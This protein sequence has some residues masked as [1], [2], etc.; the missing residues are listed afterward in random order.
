M[1]GSQAAFG[2]TLTWRLTVAVL[3]RFTNER[4]FGW[5][6]WILDPLIMIAVYAVILGGVLGVVPRS[7]LGTY[8][9]FLAC[10]LIP[11]RWNAVSTTRAANAFLSN[12]SLL[13][14]TPVNRDAV[15]LAELCASSIQALMGIPVLIGFMLFYE[16]AFSINLLW[17]PVPLFV[18]GVFICGVGYGLCGLT[19]LLRDTANAY[20]SVL[21]VLWFLSP[22]L[23][24]LDRV[25]DQWRQI[26]IY[27]N[28]FAG[29]LEGVRRPIHDGLPPHWQAL[30][31][32]A[33]WAVAVLC[34]GRLLFV[35]LRNDA[36][37]ML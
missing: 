4:M 22:G 12:A 7:G 17:L 35:R 21:R 33:V 19:V 11:W 10:G 23:Y 2:P 34:L 8:P 25:P 1:A 24:R 6:W 37:R 15:L 31:A 28:P 20:A 18:M 29:M 27:C 3:Q 5:W 36:I 14:A 16:C 9:L 13:T 30:A 26:Y 32:S